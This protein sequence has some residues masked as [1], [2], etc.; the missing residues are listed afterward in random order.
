M[1]YPISVNWTG[2]EERFCG[3]QSRLE[4]LWKEPDLPNEMA[5]SKSEAFR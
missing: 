4:I 3:A 2:L 1:T 5:D